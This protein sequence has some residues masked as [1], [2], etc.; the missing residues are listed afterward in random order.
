MMSKVYRKSSEGYDVIPVTKTLSIKDTEDMEVAILAYIAD[1]DK[2]N[3]EILEEILV[4]QKYASSKGATE[5]DVL[6]ILNSKVTDGI[7]YRSTRE[8][9]KFLD[10]TPKE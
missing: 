7:L 10:P 1:T 2:T 9:K 3:D 5:I 4:T 8:D 6:T